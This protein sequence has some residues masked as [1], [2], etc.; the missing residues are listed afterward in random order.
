MDSQTSMELL[1]SVPC[2]RPLNSKAGSNNESGWFI[3]VGDGF[4]SHATKMWRNGGHI[5]KASTMPPPHL[6]FDLNG[7]W[8]GR[9][10]EAKMKH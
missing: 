8:S 4:Q 5:T 9:R 6:R 3:N 2:L 7:L 1:K 10:V